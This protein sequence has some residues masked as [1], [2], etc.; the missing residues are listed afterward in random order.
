MSATKIKEFNQ[1]TIYD[2]SSS[3]IRAY[4]DSQ[5]GIDFDENAARSTMIDQ[6]IEAQGW[7]AKDPSDGATHV[8]I[9][10]ARE[11][12]ATGNFPWKGGANGK[13]FSI[14][15]DTPTVIP[16]AYWQAIKSAQNRAG[17]TVVPLT[18]MLED[19][20][21]EKRIPNTGAPISILRW[22]TK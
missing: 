1:N 8:E 20:P 17:F 11:P 7:L 13:L 5:C 10:I 12:G 21:S 9:M 22:I 2:A 6:V 3:E 14:K 16:M 15:R 19:T 18:D 4:A